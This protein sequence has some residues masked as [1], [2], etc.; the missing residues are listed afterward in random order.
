M[1][2][3]GTQVRRI[4]QWI[5]G[6][7]S[8][9]ATMGKAE[10]ALRTLADRPAYAYLGNHRGLVVLRNECR[11]F[12]DTRD[13]SV[14]PS[15][16]AF[17]CWE[18]W[19]DAVVTR[20]TR[21]GAVAVDLGA[22]FGYFTLAL[23]KAA[24]PTGKVHAFEANSDVASLLADTIVVNGLGDRVTLHNVAI[25]DRRDTVELRVD[26]R[27]LGGSYI[28]HPLEERGLLRH[29]VDGMTLCDALP[30]ID[31]IDMLRMD[32]EGCEPL[33]LMGAEPLI[34][35]S[36]ELIIVS[37]WS[38]AMMAYHGREARD[39]VDWLVGLGFRFWRISDDSVLEPVPPDDML[40]LPHCDVVMARQHLA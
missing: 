6:L 16:I 20:L 17:G 24:G 34:R 36:P 11:I 25:L 39:L 29:A 5:L 3:V 15:L 28:A 22:N 1:F 40:V 21:S 18:P 13:I 23:A 9:P 38:V 10:R 31:R 26:P 33:A 7:D 19:V 4:L 14:A 35:Q 27:L 2:G 32:I 37:E 30:G 8:L 12:V